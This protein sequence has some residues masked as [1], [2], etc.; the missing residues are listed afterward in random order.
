MMEQLDR[1]SHWIGQMIEAS[2][3][4]F[5]GRWW[6]RWRQRRAE[7]RLDAVLKQFG[8]VSFEARRATNEVCEMD[9]AVQFWRA[10]PP[11][12]RRHVLLAIHHGVSI[13]DLRIMI[14]NRDLRVVNDEL[15]VRRSLLLGG[16]ALASACVAALHWSLMM[17]LID[18]LNASWSVKLLTAG[19]VSAIYAILF[20]GWSLY[21][22]RAWFAV[23]RSAQH[24]EFLSKNAG[25][26]MGVETRSSIAR[27][28][29]RCNELRD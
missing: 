24:L 1:A 2:D 3:H 29:S 10:A 6:W 12:V 18:G 13:E 25:T 5:S 22:G 27:I 21:L 11:A 28:D 4:F 14:V 15:K 7:D 20:R 19:V 9:F 23:R 16:L 8:E 17:A 26:D